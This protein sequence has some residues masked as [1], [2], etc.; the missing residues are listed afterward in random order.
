MYEEKIIKTQPKT[1]VI[2]FAEEKRTLLE[3]DYIK[4]YMNIVTIEIIP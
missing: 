3:I 2:D 4:I 1:V